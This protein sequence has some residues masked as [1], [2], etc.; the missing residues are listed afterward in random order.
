[1]NILV[2]MHSA[3][4]PSGVIGECII[5]RDEM[6][7]VV[8]PHDG[9]PLPEGPQDFDGMVILGGPMSAADDTGYPAFQPLL[10]LIRDFDDEHK[11]VLGVCLG[12][13]LIARA[14]NKPVFSLNEMELGFKPVRP[15]RDALYDPLL[16]DVREEQF[17]MQWHNDTFDMPDGAVL[18]MT[19]PDCPNQAYRIGS[20]VY[21]FQFHLEV[22]PD[23]IRA[24][25][26][27][28]GFGVAERFSPILRDL[29]NQIAG[30]MKGSFLFA[31][32]VVNRWL[33]LVEM[34]LDGAK[35]G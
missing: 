34:S 3:L 29:D 4:V 33:D 28:P 24:W 6:Y 21:S 2:V 1:M 11:P 7:T 18:L 16:Y 26:R 9:D 5:D 35:Q 10:R 22:T 32:K 31:R 15:T 25:A 8:M 19:G 30:H 27:D 20:G 23:I 14:Y 12:A 17:M 13:Q